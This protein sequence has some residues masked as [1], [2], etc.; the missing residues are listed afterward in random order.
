MI[1]I[2]L[3]GKVAVVIGA[4]RGIGQAIADAL[5]AEGTKVIRASRALPAKLDV[6]NELSV[7]S[8]FEMIKKEF[9]APYLLVNCAGIGIFKP[10]TEIS[11]AEW[12]D[13]LGTN[14]TG[15]FLC[16]REGFKLMVANGG[17]RIINIGSIADHIP[18]PH[19]TAYSASKFGL[20]GLTL[21]LNEEGKRCNI[22]VSLVSLGAVATDIW[23]DRPG[24]D[25]SDMLQPAEVAESVVHI[26]TMP[27][28]VRTDEIRILPPKG[29]L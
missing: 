7:Q 24:F 12:N 21:S 27:L 6:R 18:L 14:L 26:A 17:G 8:F 23:K 25:T 10:I 20:R 11:F 16:C 2:S 28:H 29:I 13:V 19:N 5:E 22:R 9:G 3:K 15:S 1:R 4:S